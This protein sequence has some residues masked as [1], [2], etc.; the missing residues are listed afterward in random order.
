MS[1]GIV[2][3]Y[4]GDGHFTQAIH[5]LLKVANIFGAIDLPDIT[6]TYK[7]VTYDYPFTLPYP[8]IK[9][10]LYAVR[11]P[12]VD[13]YFI[14]VDEAAGKWILRM[15]GRVQVQVRLGSANWIQFY[16]TP[17]TNT[18]LYDKPSQIIYGG[19]RG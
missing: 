18:D 13:C 9:P 7:N 15:C 17:C 14:P 3:D 4:M 8:I 10:F 11:I 5:P 16:R 12:N 2:V 6:M 19:R 1:D